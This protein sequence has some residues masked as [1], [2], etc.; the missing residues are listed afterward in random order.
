MA[1]LL[2]SPSCPAACWATRSSA[3][4]RSGAPNGQ[5][6]FLVA[7][8][9]RVQVPAQRALHLRADGGRVAW[10]PGHLD[11]QPGRAVAGFPDEQLLAQ[12]PCRAQRGADLAEQ[13]RIG[14][15]AG[16]KSGR[17]QSA[18][19]RGAAGTT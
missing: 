12:Q 7:A 15:G 6:V 9:Q 17:S 4:G 8:G 3:D 5:P 2:T 16:T 19:P 10:R 1:T 11:P 18:S 13:S 14:P